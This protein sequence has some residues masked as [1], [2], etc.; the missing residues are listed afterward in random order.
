MS[1]K[2]SHSEVLFQFKYDCSLSMT[3]GW[4]SLCAIFTLTGHQSA[5]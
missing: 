3:L 4:Y 1:F 5:L 2:N